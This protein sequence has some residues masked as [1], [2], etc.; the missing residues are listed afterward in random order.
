MDTKIL[1][2]VG[3]FFFGRG[4]LY[5]MGYLGRRVGRRCMTGFRRS[6]LETEGRC[7]KY[8]S[9]CMQW[10]L[11]ICSIENSYECTVSSTLTM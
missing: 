7:D 8:P 9:V 10:L 11:D 1:I 4:I 2:T 6:S 5:T 3:F